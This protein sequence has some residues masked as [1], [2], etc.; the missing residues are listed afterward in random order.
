ML[1]FWYE[2][3]LIVLQGGRYDWYNISC[4]LIIAAYMSYIKTNI[5][6]I[7]YNI[8]WLLVILNNMMW[9]KDRLLKSGQIIKQKL[10]VMGN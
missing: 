4:D 10:L 5:K 8:L 1:G 6:N 3:D 9:F 2:V 7:I